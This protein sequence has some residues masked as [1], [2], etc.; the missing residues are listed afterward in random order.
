MDAEKLTEI[1]LPTLE[2]EIITTVITTTQWLHN[3]PE[4]TVI[5]ISG[6]SQAF[7]PRGWYQNL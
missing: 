4:A 5:S 1:G 6:A 7:A 2:Y 3:R